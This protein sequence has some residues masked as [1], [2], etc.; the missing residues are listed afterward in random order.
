MSALENLLVLDDT[1]A[2]LDPYAYPAFRLVAQLVAA[3][4]VVTL[5]LSAIAGLALFVTALVV[6]RKRTRKLDFAAA[7][8]SLAAVAATVWAPFG[9]IASKAAEAAGR[10]ATFI[11]NNAIPI[12]AVT[13]FAIFGL[14]WSF[15]HSVIIGNV[16]RVYSLTVVPFYRYTILFIVLVV[17]YIIE[18]GIPFTNTLAIRL[19]SALVTGFIFDSG[20]CSRDLWVI[21]LNRLIQSG[22]AFGSA[23]SA[24]NNGSS[25]A[26]L[27][28]APNFM[29][30]AKAF[31]N[32]VD[33]PEAFIACLCG[34]FGTIAR[35]LFLALSQGGSPAAFMAGEPAGL[36]IALNATLNIPFVVGADVVRPFFLGAESVQNGDS[37]IDVVR[38]SRISVNG[39]VATLKAALNGTLLTADNIR[40]RYYLYV[41]E[42]SLMRNDTLVVHPGADPPLFSCYTGPIF[43]TVEAY[44]YAFNVLVA[45]AEGRLFEYDGQLVLRPDEVFDSAFF[46]PARCV[47]RWLRWLSE[48]LR[49]AGDNAA[50]GGQ[51][52]CF[53]VSGDDIGG[54]IGGCVLY[55]VASTVDLICCLVDAVLQIFESLIQVILYTLI[56]TMYTLVARVDDFT[57]TRCNIVSPSDAFYCAV[58]RGNGLYVGLEFFQ[59]QLGFRSDASGDATC[60]RSVCNLPSCTPTPGMGDDNECLDSVVFGVGNRCSDDIQRCVESE[61]SCPKKDFD[62]PPSDC[63]SE[64]GDAP[65]MCSLGRCDVVCVPLEPVFPLG[66]CTCTC[67]PDYLRLIGEAVVDAFDCLGKWFEGILSAEP[68][69]F[70]RCF[71]V[72]ISSLVTEI[73]I[74]IVDAIAQLEAAFTDPQTLETSIFEFYRAIEG[75]CRCV[76]D[77]IVAATRASQTNDPNVLGAVSA[78]NSIITCFCRAVVS[79]LEVIQQLVYSLFVIGS[80]GFGA[81][82]DALLNLVKT[83]LSVFS[84]IFGL[85][86]H[87][88]SALFYLIGATV[89]GDSFSSLGQIFCD[90]SFELACIAIDILELLITCITA[91]F[92]FI[93][94]PILCVSDVFDGFGSYGQCVEA[95]WLDNFTGCVTLLADQLFEL[96]ALLGGVVWETITTFIQLASCFFED[97]LIPSIANVT[98]EECEAASISCV[99][100]DF[101][102]LISLPVDLGCLS[103]VT[104]PNTSFLCA[105]YDIFCGI[106]LILFGFLENIED[107]INFFVDFINDAL[108]ANLART[109][110]TGG[111]PFIVRDLDVPQSCCLDGSGDFDFG[112]IC[113]SPAFVRVIYIFASERCF[114]RATQEEAFVFGCWEFL[115]FQSI[116][117]NNAAAREECCDRDFPDPRCEAPTPPPTPPPPVGSC[118]GSAIDPGCTTAIIDC[119][120]GGFSETLCDQIGGSRCFFDG[121]LCTTCPNCVTVAL[122]PQPSFGDS[123]CLTSFEDPR[124]YQEADAC[125]S[126]SLGDCTRDPKCFVDTDVSPSICN[127]CFACRLNPCSDLLDYC[128]DIPP[129]G[130]AAST[131]CGVSQADCLLQSAIPCIASS[132]QAELQRSN[133]PRGCP[134]VD[135]SLVSGNATQCEAHEGCTWEDGEGDAGLCMTCDSDFCVSDEDAGAMGGRSKNYEN[136]RVVEAIRSVYGGN[137]ASAIVNGCL[138]MF[139]EAMQSGLVTARGSWPP[140]EQLAKKSVVHAATYGGARL[141]ERGYGTPLHMLFE[142]SCVSYFDHLREGASVQQEMVL[143]SQRTPLVERIVPLLHDDRSNGTEKFQRFSRRVARAGAALNEVHRVSWP[144]I[145]ALTLAVVTPKLLFSHAVRAGQPGQIPLFTAGDGFTGSPLLQNLPENCKRDIHPAAVAADILRPT[146]GLAMKVVIGA[147]RK[148]ATVVPQLKRA[149]EAKRQSII[150]EGASPIHKLFNVARHTVLVVHASNA[151]PVFGAFLASTARSAMG[152]DARLMEALGNVTAKAATQIWRTNVLAAF[153]GPAPQRLSFAA[154]NAQV[155]RKRAFEGKSALFTRLWQEPRA[156]DEP[157]PLVP[158]KR[159][160]DDDAT[161]DLRASLWECCPQQPFCLECSVADRVSWAGQDSFQRLSEYYTDDFPNRYAP[162]LEQAVNTLNYMVVEPSRA[163]PVGTLCSFA[164][165]TTDA[166]CALSAQSSANAERCDPALGRCLVVGPLCSG[167]TG[168]PCY[169]NSTTP[170]ELQLGTCAGAGLCGFDASPPVFQSTCLCPDTF[171]TR[172]KTVSWILDRPGGPLPVPCLLNVTCIRERILPPGS[173]VTVPAT[174]AFRGQLVLRKTANGTQENFE[175]RFIQRIDTLTG[176]AATAV[177]EAIEDAIFL[178]SDT[179]GTETF[180]AFADEFLFCDYE[181]DWYCPLRD[182]SPAEGC[183]DYRCEERKQGVGLVSGFLWALIVLL[184]PAALCSVCGPAAAFTGLWTRVWAVFAGTLTL[185]FAY[186]GGLLC[187]TPGPLLLVLPFYALVTGIL[188]GIL[189]CFCCGTPG[190]ACVALTRVVVRGIQGILIL[191]ALFPGLTSCFGMDLYSVASELVPPCFP[192]PAA[193][194]DRTQPGAQAPCGAFLSGDFAEV[195]TT[196]PSIVDCTSTPLLANTRFRDGLDNVFY[197]VEQVRPGTNERIAADL[198]NETGFLKFFQPYAAAHTTAAHDADDPYAEVC[199]YVTLPSVVLSV[200]VL[201]AQGAF[202]LFFFAAI[203]TVLSLLFVPC[204]FF[205][206]AMGEVLAQVGT[207]LTAGDAS[208]AGQKQKTE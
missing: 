61:T 65:G 134:L 77:L 117:E 153:A 150:G 135:C 67:A 161:C 147:A 87:A 98:P 113:F 111:F 191:A 166:D 172:N 184:V 178:F 106:D 167:A 72:S 2:A 90:E 34:S 53:G 195:N 50:G 40:Q 62:S 198:S 88:F 96:F 35:P 16:L 201:L 76:V 84:E 123:D 11:A 32:L 45:F 203:V 187:Y 17:R 109:V 12:L 104:C 188:L 18:I 25:V 170:G 28:S 41:L 100:E 97:P 101:F 7:F 206:R 193:L 27:T 143:A 82:Q 119:S 29:I 124:C 141:E 120:F 131:V 162:C 85:I 51:G 181:D 173:N 164:E 46:E 202:S 89:P 33:V 78:I 138:S 68:A 174:H 157:A 22:L 179:V 58:P 1:F 154:D 69:R 102:C 9:A 42:E 204:L 148:A 54:N 159:A 182:D 163:C 105:F 132:G 5:A 165:C 95:L 169:E 133:C 73:I 194:I 107:A 99:L 44:K 130:C 59:F 63:Y 108:A 39:T 49:V 13:G 70:L 6:E 75:L 156:H 66:P 60:P 205:G 3:F 19:P 160:N 23:F 10:L 128:V 175:V 47:C 136:K 186:G 208:G 56:G 180:A 145:H 139:Q 21:T 158:V 31:S 94:A 91:L 4:L 177:V 79:V 112:N 192:L 185:A 151:G 14:F 207:A 74:F 200:F 92:T 52:F 38:A 43:Y 122:P 171:L 129:A 71:F 37:F 183:C 199:F 196:L 24:W 155:Q 110:L 118:P 121:L 114:F 64:S 125:S 146:V 142:S 55:L 86:L 140:Y 93:L 149:G 26:V 137:G 127:T 8:G 144:F 152:Q 48:T 126:Y 168:A 15:G 36:H 103:S 80:D 190:S 115:S 189:R 116:L 176:G 197:I 20:R 83:F 81:A 30:W 57:N